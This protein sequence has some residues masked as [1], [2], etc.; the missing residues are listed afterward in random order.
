LYNFPPLVRRANK[1]IH[2]LMLWRHLSLWKTLHSLVHGLPRIPE[3]TSS[4]A[5]AH[6]ILGVFPVTYIIYLLLCCGAELIWNILF[7]PTVVL[8]GPVYKGPGSRRHPFRHHVPAELSRVCIMHNQPQ[9]RLDVRSHS[10][11]RIVQL[12]TLPA[13][14]IGPDVLQGIS[15]VALIDHRIHG[16]FSALPGSKC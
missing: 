13:Y 3:D 8:A 11:N 14:H 6:L 10:D 9:Q 2:H 16:G 15:E 12:Y 7:P 4:P 5:S 1:A